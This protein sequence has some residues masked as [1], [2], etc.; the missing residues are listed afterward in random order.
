MQ[1]PVVSVIIPAY[2][3]EATIE[4]TLASA[5]AQT[6]VAL[7]IIVVDDGSKD[8]TGAIV[9]EFSKSDSRV[10]LV[11]QENSG[12][13]AARNLGL[14][15]ARGDFVAPL[16]ADDLW[17][18]TKIEKQLRLCQSSP[19]VGLVYTWYRGIDEADLVIE[20]QPPVVARGDVYNRLL[21]QNFVGNASSPLIRR[22][23]LLKTGGYDPSLRAARA[24][25]AE[26]LQMQLNIAAISDYEV[27]PEYLMGY[28]Q[29]QSSMSTRHLEMLRSQLIVIR[30]ARAKFPDLAPFLFRWS[31][32]EASAYYGMEAARTAPLKAL[33]PLARV[34]LTD[35]VAAYHLVAKPLRRKL[36]R[37][38][39][40][41]GFELPQREKKRLAS[42]ECFGRHFLEVEP[43]YVC[44][45]DPPAWSRNRVRAALAA[46]TPRQ[47][48]DAAQT[49]T[50]RL[51]F[52]V[53]D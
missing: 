27:V 45:S 28:R 12:V 1:T 29:T 50:G 5:A 49:M 47:F 13:A 20:C 7:E 3:A 48:A 2:N 11:R 16:D 41:H 18:P 46:K 8:R 14:N 25:G 23:L 4:R 15:A 51:P 52:E 9:A 35:P 33:L 17:H 19:T 22:S 39:R 32:G 53:L 43:G 10:R 40:R 6:F 30:R 21:V 44:S 42:T 26:D 36:A 24:Q 37:R 34:A 31:S 38:M